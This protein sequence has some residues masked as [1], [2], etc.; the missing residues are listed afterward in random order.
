MLLIV[1]LIVYTAI[2]LTVLFV[3]LLCY[4]RLEQNHGSDS[5]ATVQR[6]KRLYSNLF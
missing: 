5:I 2:S 1:S 4:R 3:A 6:Y